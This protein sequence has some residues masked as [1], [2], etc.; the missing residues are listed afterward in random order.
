[1]MANPMIEMVRIRASPRSLLLSCKCV[2]VAIRSGEGC[3]EKSGR[4]IEGRI[5]QLAAG[6]FPGRNRGKR[7]GGVVGQKETNAPVTA[8]RL[9]REDCLTECAAGLCHP[10]PNCR[11][12]Q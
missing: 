2:L 9:K 4:C 12:G 10:E 1:M 3:Q 11:P 8:D 5:R 6:Q 7:S